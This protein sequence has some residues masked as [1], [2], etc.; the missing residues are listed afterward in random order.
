[1]KPDVMA[2]YN[3]QPDDVFA[4]IGSQNLVAAT[5]SLGE[6]SENT[7]QYTLEYKG[8]LTSLDEFRNIVV[9][10]DDQGQ[11]LHLS[12]VAEIELGSLSYSYSSTV[13]QQPGVVFMINQAAG[14][15]ATA[16]NAQISQLYKDMQKQLPPGMEFTTLLTS[17]DFLYAAFH[18]VIETLIV[19]I[20]LVILVVFFFLQDFRATLIPSISI[21][22]SLLGTFAVVKIAGFSLNIL[23]LFALVLS[24]GTVV[25][26]AIVVVEAVM[27]KFECGIKSAH[28]ATREALGDVSV[29][30]VSCTLVFMAVFIPVTFMPG[31]S[32]TFF[33]QF[34]ITIASSVGLSCICAL[35]VC[36]ALCAMLMRPHNG[37]DDSRKGLAYYT[38][39][40]YNASYNAILG[41]Y[42]KHVA[43]FIK[44]PSVS[45]IILAITAALMIFFMKT[46]PTGLV[47]QEDQGVVLVDV[48]APAGS[49]L[50][51]T[52][53]ILSKVEAKLSSIEE[54][55]NYSKIVGFGIISGTG[56]SYGTL[57][58]RLKNWDDR[59][60]INHS[61]DMVMAK[62]YYA[63]ED[64]KDAVVMPFQMPQIPGYGNG[65]GI[66]LQI[67]DLQGG[68]MSVF[69]EHADKFVAALQQRPEI[70][71][72]VSTYSEGFPKYKV[73]VDP[74]QCARAGI[75]PE[76]VLNTLGTYCGGA[77]I[78]NFNQYGKVY[79]VMAGASPDYRL[80]P[81]SLKNIFVRTGSG[82]MAPISQFVS[83]SASAGSA[84]QKRFNLFQSI[85]CQVTAA[86]GYADS[87]AQKAISEVA[88]Q[89]LP[90]GYGFEY[91][92]MSRE[93]DANSKSN[94]T[95]IIY[96]ICIILIYLILGCLYESWFIPFAVLLSV[97]FGL[98]GSFLFSWVC[99]LEN[100][101][102]LQTG[103]IML[104]GLLAKTAILITE[105]AVAKHEKGMPIEEAALEACKDRLRPILMTVLTMIVGM[106]PLIVEG[107]AGASGN[108][109]L[110]IGV[111]G[112]MSVGTVALL[113]VVPCFYIVFQRLHD[114]FQSTDKGEE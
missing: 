30:V 81:S 77:Y 114:R 66:E 59:K 4:A 83:L 38:C 47:P 8:R 11:V 19:A 14:A 52:G 7:Y 84:V 36:P 61:I 29:A 41:K 88:A 23:T 6:Q 25:D 90:Q 109:S 80:D 39:M 26:D 58:V 94:M 55:E 48:S 113:F 87:D 68:D 28:K 40:A 100:N 86:S 57:I 46:L 31:T 72:A 110:A 74:A 17:D 71:M 106:I 73:D 51:Q 22:V 64:I 60:G 12:E 62:L 18:N 75:S 78:G 35:C 50:H 93:L 92:G 89:Y 37:S 24:I 104:I 79:R 96:I 107:G 27:T 99:G 43:K 45:W 13:D 42:S 20:L 16:V 67:E 95:G 82:K 32:G 44:R 91:G 9:R 3:L 53:E 101:I 15:N 63:C 76:T 65:N 5:G 102:Y 10:S 85:S 69:K 70:Q 97:P 111:V 56:S 49:S 54:V 98:M 34:G 112:G 21:I 103:V 2:R 105:Y 1:M 33:T 108:R